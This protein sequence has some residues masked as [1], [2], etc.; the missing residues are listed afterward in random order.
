MS[1]LEEA[2]APR[3]G[4]LAD[5]R[6]LRVSPDGR[7]IAL[8]GNAYANGTVLSRIALFDRGSPKTISMVPGRGNAVWPRWSSG[9]L[10]FLS[11]RASPGVFLP[12]MYEPDAR[13]AH[14]LA[15]IDE[16][17]EAQEWSPDGTSLLLQT[18]PR[19]TRSAPWMP[20]VEEA[21]PRDYRSLWIYSVATRRAHRL[22]ITGLSFWE[23]QWCGDDGIVAIA[24]DNPRESAWFESQ[25]V[26]VNLPEM[27]VAVLYAP[28]A[29]VGLPV[30]TR[31]GRYVAI[32]EGCCSDRGIV[33]GNV[34]LFDRQSLWSGIEVDTHGVDVTFLCARDERTFTYAGIRRFEVVCG[35]IDVSTATAREG[36]SSSGSWLRAFYPAVAPSGVRDYVTVAHEYNSPPELCE[37]RSGRMHRLSAAAERRRAVRETC[38]WQTWSAADGE[39]IDG[40]LIRKPSSHSQPL[41]TIIHGGPVWAF[42]NAWRGYVPIAAQFADLGYAVLLPNPRGSSGRGQRFAKMIAGDIGGAEAGD[43]LSGID[44]LVEQGIADPSRLAVMGASHGGYLTA[45]LVTRTNRFAAAVCAFPVCDLFSAY[46]TGT[47]SESMPCLIESDPFDLHG[48]YFE[49]SPV[50]GAPNVRTPVLVVGGARDSCTGITQALEFHRA[51][52]VC[53]ARSTLVTYPQEGHGIRNPQAYADYCSRV[54]AWIDSNLKI[55]PLDGSRTQKRRGRDAAIAIVSATTAI[56]IGAHHGQPSHSPADRARKP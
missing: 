16:S 53:G 44:A 2:F 8:A 42:T 28:R 24:S 56:T 26:Y 47:P 25:V 38:T 20:I 36:A 33:S 29:Q 54:L 39:Q 30:A 12:Y 5:V 18:V 7:W 32:V 19:D 4:S 21:V 46:F 11:D 14:A 1:V 52:A 40:L 13:R 45:M 34:R 9:S 43:V 55:F 22:P 15:C 17:V 41:V 23:A 10:T 3:F 6:D 50:Y 27:R 35:D 37:Y 49:R 51:L 31:D 48:A